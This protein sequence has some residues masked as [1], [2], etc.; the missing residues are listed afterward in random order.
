LLN[1]L[2]SRLSVRSK[3]SSP[4]KLTGALLFSVEAET[5]VRRM[6]LPRLA[7]RLQKRWLVLYRQHFTEADVGNNRPTFFSDVN[8]MA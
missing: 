8:A 5:A 3:G 4:N 7:R 2:P 6:H 1:A